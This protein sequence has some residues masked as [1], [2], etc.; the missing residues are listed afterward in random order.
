[1]KKLTLMICS[2]M[3][4]SPVMADND[5]SNL[6][7]KVSFQLTANKW[8]TSQTAK[9][10]VGVDAGLTDAGIAGLQNQVLAKLKQIA[11]GD[12]HI[13]SFT[14]TQ[15]KSGLESVHVN[16]E[17]R[18]PQSAL[19]NLRGTAKSISKPGETYT[20]ADVEF[21]P[22]DEELTQANSA[23]RAMIYTQAKAELDALNKE[24]PEQKFYIYQ[25]DFNAMPPVMPMAKSMYMQTAGAAMNVTTVQP[26][27]VGN[28]QT[29]VANVV[30]AS[31]PDGLVKKPLLTNV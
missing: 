20:I 22:S 28:K 25:I 26:L 23:L 4:M 16:A 6:L 31:M 12:W 19:V 29:V 7:N 30:L 18:L 3:I 24:Y 8:V 9:V 17:A 1:M 11:A 10:N 27:N 21:I 13:T 2:L 5:L 14:R 15:D